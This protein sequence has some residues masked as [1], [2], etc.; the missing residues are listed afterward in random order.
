VIH[1]A[2]GELVRAGLR[3]CARC[4]GTRKRVTAPIDALPLRLPVAPC[5]L[6][7]AAPTFQSVTRNKTAGTVLTIAFVLTGAWPAAA[8]TTTSDEP[9]RATVSATLNGAPAEEYDVSDPLALQPGRDLAVAVEVTNT[10]DAPLSVRSVRLEG[11]VLGVTFLDYDTRVDAVV[12]PGET[13]DRSYDLDLG[14]LNEQAVGLLPVELSVLDDSRDPVAAVPF[15][16]DAR[17]DL[18]SAYGLFGLLV[19]VATAL[20]LAGA[21]IHLARGTLPEHRWFRA[22]RFAVPGAGIGLTVAV[23]LSVLRVLV[24]DPGSAVTVVVACTLAGLVLGF[25]TP[26]PHYRYEPQPIVRSRP[27]ARH[28]QVTGTAAGDTLDVGDVAGQP[29]PESPAT[30]R[31]PP[32]EPLPETGR[33]PAAAAE[34]PR[35][36]ATP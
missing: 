1:P 7:A 29:V 13:V 19:A 32:V 9:V 4:G 21:L 27:T 14:R 33:R 25:L 6:P 17:G 11:R 31:T 28:G 35:A 20:L 22:V 5:P 8:Q 16:V 36:E 23:T 30:P 12:A 18:T 2:A 26:H 15:V 10:G 34:Q 24:P 3:E